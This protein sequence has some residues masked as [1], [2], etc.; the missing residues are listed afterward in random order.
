VRI[1]GLVVALALALATAACSGGGSG[2]SDHAS[3]AT[4]TSVPSTTRLGASDLCPWF[5]GATTQLSSTGPTA[6][7]FLIDATAGAQGCLDVVTF[8]FQTQGDGTPPGYT[9]GYRDPQKDPFLDGDPPSPIDVPGSAFL[10]VTILPALSTDP[11]VE[12]NPSTYLGNLSLQYGDHHH[13]E[14]VR[15]LPDGKTADGQDTINWVIGLGAARPFRVDR[16]AN[17]PRVMILIG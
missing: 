6:P 4:T 16:A 17:P 14:I 2:A 11:T 7:G 10:A 3:G 13:L 9:V 1:R 12:G 5:R 8:T 15:E